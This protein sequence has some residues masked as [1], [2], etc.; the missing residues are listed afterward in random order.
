MKRAQMVRSWRTTWGWLARAERIP[1]L[2][3]VRITAT[4][5]ARSRRWTSDVAACYPAVKAAIDG[6]VDAGVLDD[7][8]PRHLLSLTFEAVRICG[9]DG[10]ELV[11]VEERGDAE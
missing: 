1:R 2:H 4:P 5:L 8:D 10:L 3:R 7:D 6:L 9:R 11:I